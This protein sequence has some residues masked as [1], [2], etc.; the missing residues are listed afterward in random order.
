[1]E[2]KCIRALAFVARCSGAATIAYELASALALPKGVWA[3]MSAVIVS[4]ER[5][6]E[7]QSSLAGRILGTLCGIAVTALVRELASPIAVSISVQM[8]VAVAITALVAREFPRAGVAMWTCPIILLTAQPAVP[9]FVVAFHR[10]SEVI[11]GALVGWVVHWAA[12]VIVG[13]LTGAALIPAPH[14]VAHPCDG[15]SAGW[16]AI[17]PSDD[18]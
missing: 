17:Q 3:A 14:Q 2:A 18:D 16:R 12:E 1:M 13:W 10:G 9:I 6:H 15:Q 5:L 8:M 11:L 7:T 4:Q